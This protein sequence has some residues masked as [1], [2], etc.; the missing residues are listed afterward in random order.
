MDFII[1]I[2]IITII[3]AFIISCISFIINILT[4]NEKLMK[5]SLI[6]LIISCC[7]ALFLSVINELYFL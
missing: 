3:L 7:I 6:I 5:I 4:L 2:I 1:G